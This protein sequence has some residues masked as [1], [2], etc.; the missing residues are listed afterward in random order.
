MKL[1]TLF[2]ALIFS[3]SA[4]AYF[5]EVECQARHA[6]LELLLEIEQPFPNNAIFRRAIMTITKE[7]GRRTEYHN[8]S[9]RR[10]PGVNRIQYQGAGLRLEIDLWPDAFP[11]W[12]R[13][14]NAR[15][16][17]A[18]PGTEYFPFIQCRFPNVQ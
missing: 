5:N 15:I 8:V 9:Y 1:F 16:W 17:S 7:G 18:G 14:Y 3:I 13:S 12:G 2:A 11:R 6:D 10:N 4:L